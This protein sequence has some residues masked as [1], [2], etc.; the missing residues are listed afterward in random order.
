MTKN[1]VVTPNQQSGFVVV[2][3]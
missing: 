3:L 1:G 2:S